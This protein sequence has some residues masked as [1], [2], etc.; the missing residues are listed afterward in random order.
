MRVL[1]RAVDVSQLRQFFFEIFINRVFNRL[2]QEP[3]GNSTPFSLLPNVIQRIVSNAAL[4][5]VEGEILNKFNTSNAQQSTR[6]ELFRSSPSTCAGLE[7]IRC[8]ILGN[9]T[10]VELHSGSWFSLLHSLSTTPFIIL[11]SMSSIGKRGSGSGGASEMNITGTLPSTGSLMLNYASHP[12]SFH[13]KTN[14]AKQN[15]FREI[16]TNFV[17]TFG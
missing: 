14:T 17:I 5:E 3:E 12:Q 16:K 11:L 2:N 6:I 8:I 7:T 4:S 10:G 13:V 9:E 15:I 1:G